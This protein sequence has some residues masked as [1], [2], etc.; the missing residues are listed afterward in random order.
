M[1]QPTR[2]IRA[3]IDVARA[4]RCLAS[5]PGVGWNGEGEDNCLLDDNHVGP[6]QPFSGEAFYTGTD[7]LIVLQPALTDPP[8]KWCPFGHADDEH[9]PES[10]CWTPDDEPSERNT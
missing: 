6:H 3:H 8:G 9:T 2:P 7:D 10:K 1:T 4:D 5:R